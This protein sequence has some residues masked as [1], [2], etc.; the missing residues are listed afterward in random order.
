MRFE[1]V[2]ILYHISAEYGAHLMSDLYN[3]SFGKCQAYCYNTELNRRCSCY[4]PVLQE[5]ALFFN[6]SNVSWCSLRINSTEDLCLK[7][8]FANLNEGNRFGL[9]HIAP[10]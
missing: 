9:K 6:P 4:Y 2:G 1:V 10:Y 8:A 3:Y 7:E 5:G